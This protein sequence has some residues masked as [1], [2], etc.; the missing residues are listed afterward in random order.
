MDD[1]V[2]SVLEQMLAGGG[3]DQ[4]TFK[5]CCKKLTELTKIRMEGSAGVANDVIIFKADHPPG[6]D[7][8]Y[9]SNMAGHEFRVDVDVQHL[10]LSETFGSVEALYQ[11]L[12]FNLPREFASGG[13]LSGE[14]GAAKLALVK[15]DIAEKLKKK[16]EKGPAAGWI[17][18][19]CSRELVDDKL[20]TVRASD[21]ALAT[22]DRSCACTPIDLALLLLACQLSMLAGNENARQLLE[23]TG[24]APLEEFCDNPK[25]ELWARF[26]PVDGTAPVGQNLAGQNLMHARA[27]LRSSGVARLA[28]CAQQL[29]MV[30]APVI[31][32]KEIMSSHSANFYRDSRLTYAAVM[33]I[34]APRA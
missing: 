16:A 5:D 12:K 25:G 29:F 10:K 11:G 14:V 13:A 8:R 19:Y 17:A 22:L 15:P 3:Q 18:W 20:A 34:A 4:Q 31:A 33:A 32:G 23:R 21:P 27:L 6:S 30:L 28:T 7:W 2:F 9:L 24:E 1:Q 26:R